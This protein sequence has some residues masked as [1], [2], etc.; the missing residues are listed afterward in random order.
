M[1]VNL[2]LSLTESA[3]RLGGTEKGGFVRFP[4]LAL[5]AEFQCRFCNHLLQ[6]LHFCSQLIRSLVLIL[7]MIFF[8]WRQGLQPFLQS[9]RQWSAVGS[10]RHNSHMGHLVDK[11]GNTLVGLQFLSSESKTS[12]SPIL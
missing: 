1:Q 11:T 2:L 10:I 12:F 3:D 9:C 7:L 6:I 4:S 8:L 5:P